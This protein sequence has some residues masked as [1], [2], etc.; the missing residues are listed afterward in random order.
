MAPLSHIGRYEIETELGRGAMGAVFRAR[1]PLM[2]R[3][4]AVKTILSTAL[5][6][7]L[8]EEYRE[9]FLREARAAG[10]LSHPGIVTV[11]D[12]GEFESTPYLVMEYVAGRTLASAL[13][14][15]ERFSFEQIYVLGQQIAE[16]LGFAH[17]SGVIHRDIKPANILLTKAP[18]QSA[19]RA[20][21]ADFGVAKLSATQMTATGQLLGTPSFMP[22][23]QFTGAPIDGRSDIFS[24]GVILYSLATGDKPFPGDTLTAVSYKV[25]HTHPLA[26]RL[27]NPAVPPDLDRVILKCLEKDPANRYSRGEELALD[28]SNLRAGLAPVHAARRAE[29][30]AD[31]EATADIRLP[32]DVRAGLQKPL[33]DSPGLATTAAAPAAKPPTPFSHKLLYVVGGLIALSVITSTM[34]QLGQRGPGQGSSGRADPVASDTA[35]PGPE[36]IKPETARKTPAAGTAAN[37]SA[38]GTKG[39]GAG[40]SPPVAPIPPTEL[41]QLNQKILAQIEEARNLAEASGRLGSLGTAAERRMFINRIGDS[42]PRP[43]PPGMSRLRVDASQIPMNI[44]FTIAADGQRVFRARGGQG[45][46]HPV[47]ENLFL[48]PGDHRLEIAFSAMG[49]E[50]TQSGKLP[51]ALEAGQ[52]YTMTLALQGR[53]IEAHVTSAGP[54]APPSTLK[55]AGALLAGPR[56][57][58]ALDLSEI[59]DGVPY[60]IT[61]DGNIV[62]QG[63]KLPEGSTPVTLEVPVGAHEMVAY[64]GHSPGRARSSQPLQ[65]DFRARENRKLRIGFERQLVQAG[66]GKEP[67]K[68]MTGRLA[69]SLE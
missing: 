1:D 39:P 25:V 3:V 27:I 44:G 38:G 16:A 53:S 31:T 43:V 23:E 13:E 48:P 4:V 14:S 30:P 36:K 67:R 55:Q 34:L 66:P 26:P 37:K 21:I 12:V 45:L 52:S 61:L 19:E 29:K 68:I 5:S 8:A 57:T 69:L 35:A 51:V 42:T 56:T 63:T 58:V 18:G 10:R 2:D 22:P 9:R 47:Y 24:L 50:F 65:A 17:A 33:P 7:P 62:Y 49:T 60:E 15:G 11:F 6:G 40:A 28:L 20:K 41:V 32:D 54:V 59:P 46:M 64:L